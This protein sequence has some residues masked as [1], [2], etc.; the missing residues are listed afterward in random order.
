M[1]ANQ[2]CGEERK[3]QKGMLTVKETDML[4]TKMDLLVKR[5]DL[6][7]TEKEAMKSTV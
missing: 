7:A 5:L 4:A 6:R 2:S 1:V 3:Q